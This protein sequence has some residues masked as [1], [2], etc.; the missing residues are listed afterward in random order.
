MGVNGVPWGELYWSV[1]TSWHWEDER[2]SGSRFMPGGPMPMWWNVD[3]P[4]GLAPDVPKELESQG[5]K[6]SLGGIGINEHIDMARISGR[7][8]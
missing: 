8:V 5:K 3:M 7:K 4:P 2:G 6:E 1:P